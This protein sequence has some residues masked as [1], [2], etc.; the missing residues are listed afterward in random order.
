MLFAAVSC[1]KP[2]VSLFGQ[3]KAASVPAMLIVEKVVSGDVLHRTL[4]KPHGLAVDFRGSIYVVDAGNNRLLRFT[5]E[6]KPDLEFGGYGAQQGLLNRPTFL[7]FDNG[8][9]LMV[10]DEGNRRISRYNSQLSFVD[11]LPFY[12]DEDP[13]KFGYPSGLAFTDYGETWVADRDN[14]RVAVFNNVGNFDRFLGDLGYAGGQLNS[15]EKIVR[16]KSG[17]F[18]VCDAGNQRL[19]VYDRYG[20]YSDEI[21]LSLAEYP[22]AVDVS[23]GLIWVLDTEAGVVYCIDG[24]GDILLVTG[25]TI[26]G[27]DKALK[28]PLDILKVSPD[29]LLIS[30][31]GN[32]RIL[33]CRIIYEDN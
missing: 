16:D 30:D 13:L 33:L 12:D 18:F 6:M 5:A 11:E 2:D 14:N 7:S 20:N 27:D 1:G 9:N 15:P 29:R 21:D 24:G 28:R 26:T 22:G 32:N 17:S 3:E 8:L 4:S 19:V 10:S 25:R 31:S 23:A